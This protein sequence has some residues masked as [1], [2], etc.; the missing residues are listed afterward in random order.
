LTNDPSTLSRRKPNSPEILNEPG[1][2]L[3]PGFAAVGGVKN[4]TASAHHPSS[5]VINKEDGIEDLAFA[6][7]SLRL[8]GQ[9]AIIRALDSS[10][11]AGDPASL[12][13]H[14]MDCG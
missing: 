11:M 2:S 7:D 14:K 1:G 9:A 13:A 3:T 4:K 5:S 12:E 8:P 10:C 6:L